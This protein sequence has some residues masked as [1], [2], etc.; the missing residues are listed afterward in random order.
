MV[1]VTSKFLEWTIDLLREEEKLFEVQA[2][3]PKVS[4][5]S[6]GDEVIKDS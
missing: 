1:I 5:A 4:L 6:E 3:V 2:N